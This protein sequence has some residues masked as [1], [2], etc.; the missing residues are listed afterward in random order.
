MSGA[1]HWVDSEKNDST[2]SFDVGT[3]KLKFISAPPGLE[4][5]P[6]HLKL[7]ELRNCLCLTSGF[8]SKQHVD[9]YYIDRHCLKDNAK[10]KN[11]L[12]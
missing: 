8:I 9:I 11:N 2:Y 12:E 3:E 5:A 4:T 1:L 6:I 7:I 10:K